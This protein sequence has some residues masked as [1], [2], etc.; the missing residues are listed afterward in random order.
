MDRAVIS[1]LLSGYG[2]IRVSPSIPRFLIKK[3]E[4]NAGIWRVCDTVGIRPGPKNS[5]GPKRNSI[6]CMSGTPLDTKTRC[7]RVASSPRSKLPPP[8]SKP[9]PP[10]TATSAPT[11]SSLSSRWFLKD[12]QIDGGLEDLQVA[13]VIIYYVI[14]LFSWTLRHWVLSCIL[15]VVSA[16]KPFYA[17]LGCVAWFLY[18]EHMYFS[19]KHN[20][21][22]Y[23]SVMHV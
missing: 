8:G 9:P 19:S 20:V 21:L 7:S 5:L 11:G 15:V 12:T 16:H 10:A 4:K 13:G 14:C 6:F 18:L 17:H 22:V 1:D 3:K 2:G 23:G